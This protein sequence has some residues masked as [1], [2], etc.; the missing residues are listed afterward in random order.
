MI[1]I[2]MPV[3]NGIDFIDESVGSV[4][5]QTYPNWELI[6]GVNGHPAESEVFH[7]ARKYESDKVRVL[8]FPLIKG[9]SN[10][11]NEMM[12]HCNYDHCALLD[13]DD[14]WHADKLAVQVPFLSDYDVVGA[15]CIYF[16]DRAGISPPIP[17]GDI[18]T[19]NF[20]MCNPVINSS[21][22]IR[23]ELCH[24]DPKFDGIEYYDLWLSLRS[25]NKR[26]YNCSEILVKHRIH[27]ASAFNSKG[28]DN[29][30]NKLF[31][32][33]SRINHL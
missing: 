19:A 33:H 25:Q 16:G 21:A 1:T 20:V 23:T 3:Y 8:D 32:K 15:R 6:I 12:K 9:K 28:H 18:S 5:S 11:L 14:I 29:L 24:W 17:L 27:S 22:I 31:K 4:L 26:F 7:T 10:A 13:V 30:I 2:L